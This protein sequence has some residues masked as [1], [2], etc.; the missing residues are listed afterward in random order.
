MVLVVL[1]CGH[2]ARA[3]FDQRTS[4]SV[5]GVGPVATETDYVPNVCNCENGAASFEALKAQAV[6]ARTFAYFKMNTSGSINNGTSDQVYSC[7]GTAQSIHYAAAAAT[8]G[9]I[10]SI[11]NFSNNEILLASFYVA[12]A[13]PTGPFNPAAPSAIPNPGDSDPTST[14]QWVTYPYEAGVTS[15][16]NTGTP[17]GFVG[18]PSNPNWPNRGAKSQNGADFLSDN[19]VSYVD[20]LKYFYGADVQL[21]TA[22]TDQT[23]G[24]YNGIKPLT[25]FDDYGQRNG[26]TFDGHEGYFSRSPTFS[27]STTAN[28]AGS[29]AERSSA[30]SQ[31]G[32]HSQLI[33]IDYDESSGT[34]FLMRHVAGARLSDF[35]GSSNAATGVANLK[36][37]SHGAVGL[38]LKTDDPGLQVSIALDD[39]TTGDRGVL[40]DVVADGQWREYRWRLDRPSDWEAWTAGGNGAID[41][42]LVS[43]DSIQLIGASDAEVYLDTVF[44]D[45]ADI[46]TPAS[47]GD[48]NDDGRVDGAD[49]TVWRDHFL[50]MGENLPGDGDGNK[51]VGNNDLKIWRDNYGLVLAT[52]QSV[53][54]P[55]ALATVLCVAVALAAA[56]V[57]PARDRAAR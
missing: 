38:W 14:Q 41:G 23:A 26:A 15:G 17:L 45:P 24:S 11:E 10:L 8:E 52:S 4:I 33:T 6:A 57:A 34:D 3:Q 44:W 20:I 12:G 40:R 46:F 36:F 32:G 5:N 19:S 56:R 21:R 22:S 49:F 25:N 47:V 53:P 54:E 2:N 50:Q 43:L 27:G 42:D 37:E 51:F 18:T 1:A 29:T 9:E 31:S 35:D 30:E 16:D 48:Y 7:S 39:P 28:I 13:I 55:G